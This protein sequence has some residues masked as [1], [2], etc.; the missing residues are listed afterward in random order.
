MNS[1]GDVTDLKSNAHYAI[2]TLLLFVLER[3]IDT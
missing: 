2:G 3:Q 1:T